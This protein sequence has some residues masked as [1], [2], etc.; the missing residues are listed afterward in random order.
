MTVIDGTPAGSVER[1][2]TEKTRGMLV[3]FVFL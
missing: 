2:C 3:L 1:A